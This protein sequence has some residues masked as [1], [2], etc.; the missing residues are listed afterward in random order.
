[1]RSAVWRGSVCTWC[2]TLYFPLWEGLLGG[3]VSSSANLDTILWC[4]LKD[5]HQELLK[6][7]VMLLCKPIA[8]L[9]FECSVQLFWTPKNPPK[10][11][12]TN[13]TEKSQ[14]F[15]KDLQD[16]LLEPS[17]YHQCCLLYCVPCLCVSWTPPGLVTSPPPWAA[18]SSAQPL[19]WRT[20]FSNIQAESSLAQLEAIPSLPVAN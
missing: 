19:F 14:K 12:R 15:K 17:T 2:S 18:H 20:S 5:K 3:T 7:K 10:N 8:C 13:S 16:H 9:Y 1:M 4:A 6:Y 11:S